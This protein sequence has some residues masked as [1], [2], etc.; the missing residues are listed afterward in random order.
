MT[1]RE[2]AIER[3]IR[4]AALLVFAGLAVAG[5]TLFWEHPVTFLVFLLVGGLLTLAG[6]VSYLLALVARG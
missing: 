1:E 3:R 5:V 6:A 2:A 4:A